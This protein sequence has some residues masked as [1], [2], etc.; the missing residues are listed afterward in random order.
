MG[1]EQAPE[2]TGQTCAALRNPIAG[3]IRLADGMK[4]CTSANGADWQRW[5]ESVDR[6]AG[7]LA[8]R[9]RPAGQSMTAG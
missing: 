8:V 9:L 2:I 5:A 1:T 4:K 7:E 6:V 3:L